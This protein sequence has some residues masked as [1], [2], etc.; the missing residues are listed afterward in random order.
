MSMLAWQASESVRN[1]S[2]VRGV[3]GG[4][5]AGGGSGVDVSTHDKH[6]MT[7]VALHEAS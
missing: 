6:D 5:G 3:R 2:L 1:P 7:S 4:L